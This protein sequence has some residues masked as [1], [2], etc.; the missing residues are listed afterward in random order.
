MIILDCTVDDD[1]Q[2][3]NM[4]LLHVIRNIVNP[5]N[6]SSAKPKPGPA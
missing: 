3:K 4:M 6:Q 2:K 5:V 1:E